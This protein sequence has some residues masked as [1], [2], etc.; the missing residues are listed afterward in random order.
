MFEPLPAQSTI[1]NDP[2]IDVPGTTGSIL[3]LLHGTVDSLGNSLQGILN[4]NAHGVS[5]DDMT[6][7]C[8]D[9]RNYGFSRFRV[10]SEAA[11]TTVKHP[12]K[13]LVVT[14][15]WYTDNQYIDNSWTYAES[16]GKE[17]CRNV[18]AEWIKKLVTGFTQGK[19]GLSCNQFGLYHEFKDSLYSLHS[20]WL[21]RLTLYDARTLKL[22][23]H[24]RTK[25]Y[26]ELDPRNENKLR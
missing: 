5:F 21:R 17:G 26:A 19:R 18:R 4:G 24:G 11:T 2:A 13:T 20:L 3:R 23:W 6:R 14:L 1:H 8:N 22:Y 25:W 16:G 10:S 12:K 9:R 7:V 15:P